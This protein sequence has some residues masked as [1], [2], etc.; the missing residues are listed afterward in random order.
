M[1]NDALFTNIPK[2]KKH[3]K[4]EKQLLHKLATQT[5]STNNNMFST[6]RLLSAYQFA[7]RTKLQRDPETFKPT[8]KLFQRRSLISAP[9]SF[10]TFSD[11]M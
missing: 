1:E 6:A 5:D 9:P 8:P 7:L 3:T 4:Q 2:N 10:Y 11:R